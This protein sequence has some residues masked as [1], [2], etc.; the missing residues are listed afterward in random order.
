MRRGANVCAFVVVCSLGAACQGPPPVEDLHPYSF[1]EEVRLP[2]A[3]TSD[4][5]IRK[6]RA[7]IKPD[8]RLLSA[9]QYDASG[10][11]QSVVL[12]IATTDTQD[13]AFVIDEN[14]ETQ[15][16]DEFWAREREARI[17]RFGRMAPT[18]FT[19]Q[20]PLQSNDTIDVVISLAA[21]LPEPQRPYDGT[22]RYVSV[23]AYEA[24]LADNAAAQIAR[25]RVAKSRVL[26]L[27]ATH[28]A[29]VE[30]SPDT[31][32]I[33]QARISAELL[34]SAELNASDVIRIDEVQAPG[35]LLGYAGAA[36]MNSG[37]LSGGVCDGPCN[38]DHIGVGLWERDQF[39]AVTSGIA[40]NN[41]RI[42]ST[43]YGY[44]HAPTPCSQ[45]TDC[46]TGETNDAERY[47][48]AMFDGSGCTSNSNCNPGDTCSNGICITPKICVQDHLTWVAASVGMN[49]SYDYTTTW[50]TGLADPIPNVPTGG[51]CVGTRCAAGLT[52]NALH[53]CVTMFSPWSGASYVNFKVGN[54]VAQDGLDY[55]L[56]NTDGAPT[57]FINR[58]VSNTY[59]FIDWA[60]RAYGTFVTAAAG[61]LGNTDVVQCEKLRNGLCVGFYDYTTY[62][63]LAAHRRSQTGIFGSNFVNDVSFDPTLE[64]PHLLGPGNHSS[65]QSGLHMPRIDAA[66]GSS[67]MEHSY[68]TLANHQLLQ[69]VGSS[70]S[71][72]AVL[73]A[74][75]Q[76]Q[77]YEGWFSSLAYPMVNKAVLM[78]ST[79][80]A[81]A[82]GAIGKGTTWSGQPSDAEDG[83]GQLNFGYIKQ[84][85][86]SNTYWFADLSDSDFAPCGTGCRTKTVASIAIPAQTGIRVALAWQS[87]LLSEL[88][89][90]VISND[91]DVALNCGNPIQT[92]G[93]TIVSNTISSE[94]EMIDKA[95]CTFQR[96][97]TIEVRIKN[98]ATLQACGSTTTE[99]VGVAWSFRY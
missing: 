18:L 76:A 56:S 86:D 11:G 3:L 54:S 73:S 7:A 90:P 81:N 24:W 46:T 1:Q 69:V 47:C 67:Q 84:I 85:L 53:Q 57:P 60:G 79:Q 71:A 31:L 4:E 8:E 61:D 12:V 28:A 64:R 93:G 66:P 75:I 97:C 82:D 89:T 43:V 83:G 80:D 36:S 23:A 45:D 41:T 38:G 72:P 51:S 14:N 70:F 2:H 49:G 42:N 33:I 29:N 15:P 26:G 25:I 19:R 22:D 48:A 78:A 30:S 17:A 13:R 59:A 9:A 96:S 27:L 35:V 32:P 91:L 62:N 88:S 16:T 87:C 50:P 39:G 10:I 94:L 65:T 58:S 44:L 63:D 95:K 99:R 52:C 20:A 5:V 6:A 92:C 55:L 74:A 34:R 68:Y 98:G 21:D 40:R 77:Q 37:A